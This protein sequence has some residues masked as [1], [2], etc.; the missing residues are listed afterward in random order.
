MRPVGNVSLNKSATVFAWNQGEGA[1]WSCL[2]QWSWVLDEKLS[3]AV[4]N[5]KLCSLAFWCKFPETEEKLFNCYTKASFIVIANEPI[6]WSRNEPGG[7]WSPRFHSGLTI[8]NLALRRFARLTHH[9]DFLVLDRHRVDK[10]LYK[11]LLKKADDDTLYPSSSKKER[12]QV[13]GAREKINSSCLWA[14]TN[15]ETSGATFICKNHFSFNR[16]ILFEN[17]FHQCKLR[18]MLKNFKLN[19]LI[20]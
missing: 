2:V 18:R 4:L 19:N 9:A 8:I 3:N 6:L 16:N 17:F 12:L 20:R 15:T 11:K 5:Q 13:F 10:Y 14:F 7:Q 1:Q